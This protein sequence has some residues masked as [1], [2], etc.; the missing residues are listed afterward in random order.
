[1]E[2]QDQ[3]QNVSVLEQQLFIAESV[4]TEYRQALA[5]SQFALARA[6]AKLKYATTQE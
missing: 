6:N 5:D 3:E 4:I 2:E 1:M